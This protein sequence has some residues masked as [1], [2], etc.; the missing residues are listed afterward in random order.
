VRR[1]GCLS[2]VLSLL[3]WTVVIAAIGWF[4]YQAYVHVTDYKAMADRTSTV[5]AAWA[6]DPVAIAKAA[7]GAGGVRPKDLSAQ[8]FQQVGARPTVAY[9]TTGDTLVLTTSRNA[10]DPDPLA[11]QVVTSDAVIGVLVHA[12]KP[13]LPPVKRWWD[14]WRHPTACTPHNVATALTVS[15]GSGLGSR[16]V[17]DAVTGTSVAKA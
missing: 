14:E 4:G 11:V 9:R 17:V 6:A 7:A 13:W 8:P 10:C 16:I 5:G 15:V 1:L 3:L 12:D 2:V